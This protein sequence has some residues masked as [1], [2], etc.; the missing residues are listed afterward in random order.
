MHET[1][2]P[3]C[4][5]AVELDFQAVAGVVWCPICQRPFTPPAG[6]EHEAPT[7]GLIVPRDPQIGIDA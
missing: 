7:T 1:P 6:S 5:T 3:S 2:C 4:G